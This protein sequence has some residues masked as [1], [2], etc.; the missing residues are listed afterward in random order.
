METPLSEMVEQ[1]KITIEHLQKRL[2][3]LESGE[4]FKE[5][6]E[7]NKALLDENQRLLAQ[8]DDLQNANVFYVRIITYFLNKEE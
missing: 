5:A 7:R 1:Q 6:Q 2:F 8:V 4:L 3:L